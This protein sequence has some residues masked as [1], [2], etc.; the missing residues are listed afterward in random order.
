MAIFTGS[1]TAIVTPFSADES[2][3]FAE[4]GRLIDFQIEN[5]TD[6]IV[7]CGTTGEASTL[8]DD[9]H[10]E[11]I[12]FA[13]AHVN[14]RVPVIAG[15]G[16]NH[17]H[18]GV[19]LCI[20]A[21]KAGADALLLVTPYYNKATQN[22]LVQHFGIMAGSVD[23]PIIVYNVPS[24]TSLNIEPATMLKLSKIENIV[25]T[26]EASHNLGQI[27]EIAYLCG[28]KIDIYSGNDDDIIT[29]LAL[30]GKGVISVLSNIV[31]KDV[32]HMVIQYHEGKHKEAL[33][34]QLKTIPLIRALFSEVSPVPVKEALNL[35][36]MNVGGYRRPLTAIE[37][38][39]KELLV[40]AM[41]EYGLLRV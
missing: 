18:H 27:T 12:R 14:E 28:D 31:P 23:L 21:Q 5:G 13:V 1:G 33:A 36:G 40:K 39:N 20:E 4:F 32:H 10:I 26:K 8:T 17:T 15:A 34:L 16:S 37:P 7:V 9:E 22:G 38:Q 29:V 30:G 2:I 6:A 41:K 25:A 3:D 35:M 19:K 24:R 11:C